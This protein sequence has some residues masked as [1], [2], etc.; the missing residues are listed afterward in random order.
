MGHIDISEVGYELSD[1]RTLLGG[2]SLR[3]PT[4][5]RTALIGPNGSGKTTLLRIVTGDLAPHR[6]A[7]TVQGGLG[8]MRQVVVR[9]DDPTTVREALVDVAPTALRDAAHELAE[10]E[11][12]IMTVDDEPAQMRYAQAIIDW[13]GRGRVR[14]R[15]R[16]GQGHDRGARHRLRAGPVA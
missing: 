15:E 2:V 4:G 10:A 1:G 12:G 14:R 16:V 7:A 13:G 6:G 8:V 11:H 5:S 9:A 3:V